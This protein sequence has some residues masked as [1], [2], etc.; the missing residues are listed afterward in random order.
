MYQVVL[1]FDT[2]G[3]V[4][5]YTVKDASEVGR[6]LNATTPWQTIHMDSTTV[7]V[8]VTKLVSVAIID[9]DSPSEFEIAKWSYAREKTFEALRKQ[10]EPV[11]GF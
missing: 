10:A 5:T 1:A 8:N 3:L 2:A 7:H 4:Q 6:L 9:Y 11:I